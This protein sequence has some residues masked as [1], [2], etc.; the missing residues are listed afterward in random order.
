MSENDRKLGNPELHNV[1]AADLAG[2]RYSDFAPE[3]CNMCLQ[4]GPIKFL[5]LAHGSSLRSVNEMPKGDK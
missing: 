5:N 2:T 4:G 3:G 1:M